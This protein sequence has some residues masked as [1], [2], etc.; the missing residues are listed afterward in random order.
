MYFYV[1]LMFKKHCFIN[2]PYTYNKDN[3]NDNRCINI[4]IKL[5]MRQNRSL[6]D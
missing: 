2:N 4:I 3:N 5:I 1:F 6:Y